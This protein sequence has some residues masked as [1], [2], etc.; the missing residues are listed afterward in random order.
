MPGP[1][2]SRGSVDQALSDLRT[3]ALATWKLG[4]TCGGTLR[5]ASKEKLAVGRQMHSD[6]MWGPEVVNII[7]DV[8]TKGAHEACPRRED[9][10]NKSSK[11]VK[12]KSMAPSSK[13]HV[14]LQ[15][16]AL[17][18]KRC[19]VA[20]VEEEPLDTQE[21]L[22][23]DLDSDDDSHAEGQP[24]RQGSGIR[25][26]MRHWRTQLEVCGTSCFNPLQKTDGIVVDDSNIVAECLCA[27]RSSLR[28]R[29]VGAPSPVSTGYGIKALPMIAAG[30]YQFEVELQRKSALVVGWSDATTLPS[31]FNMKC[32]GYRSTGAAVGGPSGSKEYGPEFGE[33]GD[34]IGALLDWTP[35]GPRISFA[36]NGHP[37]GVAFASTSQHCAP[38]QPHI[39]QVA[40][41][42]FSVLLRGASPDV[43]LR[44]PVKGYAPIGLVSE[45]HFCPYSVAV[46]RS[47]DARVPTVARRLIH[48][49][50]GLQLPLSHVA[51]ERLAPQTAPKSDWRQEASEMD[52]SITPKASVKR[53]GA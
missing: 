42:S 32:L 2:D 41:P 28:A 38:L 10:M 43:P 25:S 4:T 9:G 8:M 3:R 6:S 24:K 40:G 5:L 48:G 12:K 22:C 20:A 50:L 30:R 36:L 13:R 35:G 18:E 53:G 19:K 46:E 11:K 23:I 45:P 17:C 29:D 14:L 31:D 33:A 26:L 52:C 47:T 21:L 44:F 7:E 1:S 16:R 15:P 34:V 51:Q 39:F 37:L 49:C 27:A